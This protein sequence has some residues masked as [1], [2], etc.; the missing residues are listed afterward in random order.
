M[1]QSEVFFIVFTVGAT[2]ALAFPFGRFLASVFESDEGPRFLGFLRVVEGAV[3]RLSGVD[4]K[5][6]MTWRQYAGCLLLLNGLGVVFVTGV[7]VL[8]Y[9]LPLNPEEF[10]GVPLLLAMNTAVS[11]VTNTNWQAYSGESSLSYITQM[12]GLTVQNFL[13]AATG[14]AVM[15]ALARGLSRR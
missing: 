12:L 3:Y 1:S 15:L 14:I 4:S 10:K 5:R 7:Q 11:F 8:Q 13:S 9:Y 6:E 2:L